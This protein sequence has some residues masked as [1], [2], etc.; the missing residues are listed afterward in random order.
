MAPSR[1]LLP[2]LCKLKS[3]GRQSW[4][5]YLFSFSRCYEYVYVRMMLYIYTLH[6]YTCTD[7]KYMHN[8]ICI[9]TT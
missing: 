7:T 9:D 3:N 1:E 4:W 2:I 5:R 6:V 8:Y